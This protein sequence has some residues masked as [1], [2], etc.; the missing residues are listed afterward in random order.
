MILI[1]RHGREGNVAKAGELLDSLPG[2][3][4]FKVSANVYSAYITVCMQHNQLALALK[5][6]DK[7]KVDGPTPDSMT[8]DK[9]ISG[10]VRLGQTDNACKLVLDAYGLNGP[11]GTMSRGHGHSGLV[12]PGGSVSRV[13]G[14]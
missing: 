8:Y 1:K 12:T 6:F 3:F 13:S 10:C 2:K 11:I 14:L 9:L 7:M 5:V 4:G